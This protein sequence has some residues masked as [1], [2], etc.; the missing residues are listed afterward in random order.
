MYTL[1]VLNALIQSKITETLPDDAV[2]LIKEFKNQ[3]ISDVLVKLRIIKKSKLSDDEI[4]IETNQTSEELKNDLTIVAFKCETDQHKFL[5]I[6]KEY[7][8]IKSPRKV[9][10]SALEHYYCFAKYA[11]DNDV[12]PL[13]NVDLNPYGIVTEDINCDAIISEERAVQEEKLRVVEEFRSKKLYDA[14][15]GAEVFKYLDFPKDIEEK[16]K[17]KLKFVYRQAA[18]IGFLCGIANTESL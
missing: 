13:K 4:R 17:E 1:K 16:G 5:E 6:F 18:I 7:F 2:C 12:L 3:E 15:I 11:S 10:L 8:G 9:T 14:D